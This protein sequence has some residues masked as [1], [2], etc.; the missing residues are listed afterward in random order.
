MRITN[1]K[2]H[3]SKLYAFSVA[4]SGDYGM[5]GFD[6]G[7]RSINIILYEPKNIEK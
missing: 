6:F 3:S 7:T 1:K 5:I 4:F 2:A